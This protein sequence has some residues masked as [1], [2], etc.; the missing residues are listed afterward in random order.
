MD[1]ETLLGL[2]V[3][4]AFVGFLVWRKKKSSSK[5]SGG[6][7]GGGTGGGAGSKYRTNLK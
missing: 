2:V 6:T 7:G 5:S 4:V 3:I 1:Q